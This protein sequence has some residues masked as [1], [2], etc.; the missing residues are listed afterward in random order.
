M[1]FPAR[2]Q[3]VKLGKGSMMLAILDDNGDENGMDFTGNA[4]SVTISTDITNVELYSNTQKTGNLVARNRTRIAYT[5]A[6]VLN[7]MTVENLKLWFLGEGV[8]QQQALASS[9]SVTLN[10]AALG[11]YYEVGARRITNVTVQDGSDP[12]V[13]NVDY[14]LNS[15]YGIIY[16][17]P[18]SVVLGDGHDIVVMFD[19][20][21]LDIQTI[22]IGKASSQLAR[23]L[24]LS[25]DANSAG[26]ASKDRL[27]VWKVDVAPDGDLNLISDDY[28]TFTL[29]MPVLSDETNHPD[30][31][32]GKLERA[33]TAA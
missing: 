33:V 1:T 24:Y 2:G 14:E 29:T 32:Y 23:M 5:I 3:N 20:P 19:K 22:R 8:T 13:L 6:A 17:K 18:E 31:P 27:E 16:L 25:D 28:G 15:E 10:A 4:Q 12:G 11:K 9:Q 7:E 21:A 30:D 26:V